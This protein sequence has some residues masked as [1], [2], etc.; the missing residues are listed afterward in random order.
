MTRITII[1]RDGCW[2]VRQTVTCGMK[3]TV[4]RTTTI[5]TVLC[6]EDV[7]NCAVRS[8][9]RDSPSPD[10][11]ESLQLQLL[12]F[13]FVWD[14]QLRGWPWVKLIRFESSQGRTLQNTH[15]VEFVRIPAAWSF[16]WT[17]SE[18]SAGLKSI[19]YFLKISGQCLSRCGRTDSHLEKQTEKASILDLIIWQLLLQIFKR[20]RV[21]KRLS[22]RIS[23][24]VALLIR[25]RKQLR[26]FHRIQPLSF[27]WRPQNVN[28][29]NVVSILYLFS[30]REAKSEVSL[31]S[32]RMR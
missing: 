3:L 31:K 1:R 8:A 9:S 27:T 12:D 25:F 14:L 26:T 20:I 30:G 28:H 18:W 13:H 10:W 16:Q 17:G 11:P 4:V 2:K 6:P 32:S 22:D 23:A 29:G 24:F 15:S 19:S 5:W 21:F 7:F